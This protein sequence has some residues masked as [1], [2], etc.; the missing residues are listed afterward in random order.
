MRALIVEGHTNKDN[1]TLLLSV[2]DQP[3]D[4]YSRCS[5]TDEF[6]PPISELERKEAQFHKINIYACLE[7]QTK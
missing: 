5:K 7:G 1:Y 3:T 4:D 6:R 2:R